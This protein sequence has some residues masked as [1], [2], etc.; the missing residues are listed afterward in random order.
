MQTDADAAGLVTMAKDGTIQVDG[1]LLEGGGQGAH[2][3]LL[4][5]SLLGSSR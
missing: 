1:S 2:A 4:P 3:S 5:M